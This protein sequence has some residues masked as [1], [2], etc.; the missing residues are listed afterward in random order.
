[1]KVGEMLST[2]FYILTLLRIPA[3][4]ASTPYIWEL[5][6]AYLFL[7]AKQ[8]SRLTKNDKPKVRVRAS[9]QLSSHTT[10]EIQVSKGSRVS[11]Y[12]QLG[13]IFIFLFLSSSVRWNF[14]WKHW[15][16]VESQAQV[17]L[18]DLVLKMPRPDRGI[19]SFIAILILSTNMLSIC[20][21][22]YDN[23]IYLSAYSPVGR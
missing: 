4:P 20:N 6:A 3:L 11:R 13:E 17:M 9:T 15:Q 16:E 7:N 18:S 10:T 2:I 19:L 21:V 12:S 5:T 22:K 14:A 23:H 8:T 1:M